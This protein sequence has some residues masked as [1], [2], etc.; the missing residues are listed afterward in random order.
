MP[1]GFH[2]HHPG[3]LLELYYIFINNPGEIA[4]DESQSFHHTNNQQWSSIRYHGGSCSIPWKWGYPCGAYRGA[5]V[6]TGRSQGISIISVLEHQRGP[7]TDIMAYRW[8]PH[9]LASVAVVRAFIMLAVYKD[10]EELTRL[11]PARI[12]IR[13]YSYSRTRTSYHRR[14]ATGH[15]GPRI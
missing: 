7:D 4:S 6:R 15:Y 13:P 12:S 3:V 5:P 1:V 2:Y 8:N 14:K 11:R 9:M 10:S